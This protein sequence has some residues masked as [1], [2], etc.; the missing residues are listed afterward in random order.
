MITLG[1]TICISVL[2]LLDGTSSSTLS[3]SLSLDVDKHMAI[4]KIILKANTHFDKK[5]VVF[6]LSFY[7]CVKIRHH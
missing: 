5:I 2:N 4:T 1:I 6:L 3:L 7:L